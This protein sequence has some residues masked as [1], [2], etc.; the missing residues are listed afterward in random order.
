MVPFK[1]ANIFVY[2]VRSPLCV[3][4]INVAAQTS[5]ETR[6][7]ILETS[8]ENLRKIS[9]LRKIIGKYSAKH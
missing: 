1:T 3:C 8:E 7:H 4:V 5:I 2:R 9:C 6:G